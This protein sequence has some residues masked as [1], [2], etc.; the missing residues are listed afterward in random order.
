MLRDAH[1]L[2][3]ALRIFRRQ[4]L[5]ELEIETLLEDRGEPLGLAR[6]GAYARLPQL[7]LD[8]PERS[9]GERDQPFVTLLQILHAQARVAFASAHLRGRDQTAEVRISALVLD[10]EHAVR[11]VLEGRLAAD[12]RGNVLPPRVRAKAYGA[13]EPVAIGQRNC[14]Q[15]DFAGAFD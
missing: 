9:A 1:E 15:P 3:I 2:Q 5:L 4:V 7:A 8:S 13:V 14:V 12:G 11:A 10:Q 6:R